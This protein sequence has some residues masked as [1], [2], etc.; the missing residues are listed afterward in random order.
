MKVLIAGASGELGSEVA[1]LLLERGHE[2]WGLTRSESRLAELESKGLRPVR[3]DVLDADGI[4]AAVARSSPE[5]VVQVP[6]GIP[7]RGPLRPKHLDSTNRLRT[8]GT[9]NLLDAAIAAGVRRYVAE[10]I[11]AVYGYTRPD[12]VVDETSTVEREAPLPSL[13]AAVDAMHA[14][15]SMVLEA[16]LQGA[17][18]TI[19]VRLGFYYGGGTGSTRFMAKLLRRRMMAMARQGGAMPFIELS[20]GAAGVVAAL[21]KGRSGEIYN[22]VGDESVGLEDLAATVAEVIGSRPPRWIP[23]WLM[24]L[25]GR[26]AV[27]VSGTRLFVSNRKAKEELGWE[28][29]YPTVREGV[30]AAADELRRA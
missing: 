5:V 11:V 29:R 26:Y 2:V 6:I 15:E 28:P 10:S 30:E 18:E 4:K 13:Q 24:R 23:M 22:I 12:E 20:D 17:L 8:Q 21:E 25:G 7:E 1:R 3:G 9:R 27:V 14:G 16:G 19:V